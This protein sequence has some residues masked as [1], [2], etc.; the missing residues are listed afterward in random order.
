MKGFSEPYE[1][2]KE[3]SIFLNTQNKLYTDNSSFKLVIKYSLD[4]QLST[5]IFDT[6]DIHMNK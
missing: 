6:K 1:P 4:G 2:S 5:A 3:G